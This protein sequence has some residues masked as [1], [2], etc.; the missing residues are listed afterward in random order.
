[1]RRR[2]LK[3]LIALMLIATGAWSLY[4]TASHGGHLLRMAPG[5][6]SGAEMHMPMGS[7]D[8]SSH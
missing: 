5:G 1:L 3:V 7:M 8:H 2:G 4:L 6:S